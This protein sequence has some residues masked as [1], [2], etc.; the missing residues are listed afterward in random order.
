MC[1]KAANTSY[2]SR[3]KYVSG[4]IKTQEMCDKAVYQCPFVFESVPD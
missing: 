1:D 4:Q 3:N 2:P